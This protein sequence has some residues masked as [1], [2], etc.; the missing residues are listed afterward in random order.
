MGRV[1]VYLGER[2]AWLTVGVTS[3][4]TP[5]IKSLDSVGAN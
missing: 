4:S 2:V 5:V 3:V 1:K